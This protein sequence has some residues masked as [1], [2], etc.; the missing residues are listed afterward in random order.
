MSRIM[1]ADNCIVIVNKSKTQV[2]HLNKYEL[3]AVR[4]DFITGLAEVFV[5]HQ[6]KLDPTSCKIGFLSSYVGMHAKYIESLIAINDVLAVMKNSICK[7]T[8][9]IELSND[10]A[11]GI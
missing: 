10:I 7:P 5:K 2:I 8:G 6:I 3:E 11:V 9:I 1:D 4:E